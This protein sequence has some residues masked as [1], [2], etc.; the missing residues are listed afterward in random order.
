[1]RI[2][3]R[4]MAIEVDNRFVIRYNPSWEGKNPAFTKI[5]FSS[6]CCHMRHAFFDNARIFKDFLGEYPLSGT[7]VYEGVASGSRIELTLPAGHLYLV[8]CGATVTKVAL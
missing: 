1:M 3:L 8:K 7:V 5:R 2:D 6:H 4:V